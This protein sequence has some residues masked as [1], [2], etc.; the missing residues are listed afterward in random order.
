M[1]KIH[2]LSYTYTNGTEALRKVTIEVPKGHIFTILGQS[3]SGKTTLLKCVGRFLRPKSGKITL[4]GKSIYSLPEKKFRKIIGI[5]FQ[6]LYLFPHLT[7]LQNMIL[8]PIKVLGKKCTE[9]EQ[10]ARSTLKRLGIEE[11]EKSYPSQISG[12][13][14]QRVAIARALLLRPE[15]LMLDEPTSA[16]DV[17]TSDEF[18]AWLKDLNE[19]TTFI[20]VTHDIL[21]AGK[22]SSS[23]VLMKDGKVKLRGSTQYL[24][25]NDDSF[26]NQS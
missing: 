5:V 18:G 19:F 14:A 21:F 8:A 1:I 6:Q 25:E 22:I 23:G 11:I 20:I 7:V 13:Q 9:A 12:G 10:E 16:L 15:Y 3:G 24:M 17:N 2:D 26:Q 4:N